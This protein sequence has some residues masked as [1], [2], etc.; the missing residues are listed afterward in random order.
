MYTTAQMLRKRINKC[1]YSFTIILILASSL[2]AQTYI[3]PTIGIKYTKSVAPFYD[4]W[5]L[6][7]L[8]PQDFLPSN[9]L[10]YGIGVS[11]YYNNKI[12]IRLKTL[13]SKGG[14]QILDSGIAGYSHVRFRRFETSIQPF[15]TIVENMDIGLGLSLNSFNRFQV[16]GKSSDIWIDMVE[17][18]NNFHFG[19]CSSLVYR[20]KPIAINLSYSINNLKS[21]VLIRKAQNI[22]LALIYMLKTNG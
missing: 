1:F 4:S 12:S 18:Y 19:L 10:V 9:N 15:Y 8:L 11:Q 22:E 20:L 17:Q 7:T 3:E 6:Y 14:E 5:S 21:N 2:S 13:F 16:G